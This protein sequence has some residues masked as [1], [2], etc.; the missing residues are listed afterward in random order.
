MI[1]PERTFST[2]CVTGNSAYGGLLMNRDRFR[3][4]S[5]ANTTYSVCE[6]VNQPGFRKL[7][8]LDDDLFEIESAKITIK[9]DLPHQLG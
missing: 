8:Q 3:T 2:L 5:Y 9:R 1:L 7:T 4:I 6:K